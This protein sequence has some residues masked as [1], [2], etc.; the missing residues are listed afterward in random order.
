LK[1][2]VPHHS[3]RHRPVVYLTD[4]RYDEN[5]SVAPCRIPQ[6]AVCIKINILNNIFIIYKLLH[7]PIMGILCTRTGDP[8]CCLYISSQGLP[9]LFS[10]FPGHLPLYAYGTI[11]TRV[12]APHTRPSAQPRAP[13]SPSC[14]KGCIK[15]RSRATLS[16][17]GGTPTSGHTTLSL[18]HTH[19][20]N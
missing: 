17:T 12:K 7:L 18:C 20:C 14:E 1:G 13:D 3:V 6:Y 19:T 2:V 5:R 15:P 10:C 16:R 11:S 8:G 9:S 4:G